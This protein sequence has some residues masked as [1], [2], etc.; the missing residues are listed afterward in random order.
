MNEKMSSREFVS[1]FTDI[2][3]SDRSYK[4]YTDVP[5]TDE[6]YRRLCKS[7]QISDFLNPNKTKGRL[8]PKLSEVIYERC[9]YCLFP[10][11]YLDY[12][13]EI[14]V[15]KEVP[16]PQV[17]ANKF[18][19]LFSCI[20]DYNL[21]LLKLNDND[22]EELTVNKKEYICSLIKVMLNHF[23]SK[24]ECDIS[25][26]KD[27]FADAFKIIRKD[28]SIQPYKFTAIEL[29]EFERINSFC[30]NEQNTIPYALANEPET[31]KAHYENARNTFVTILNQY[32]DLYDSESKTVLISK[33]YIDIRGELFGIYNY[34]NYFK[35]FLECRDLAEEYL[36]RF[37]KILSS[38]N[39]SDEENYNKLNMADNICKVLQEICNYFTFRFMVYSE[40]CADEIFE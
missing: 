30:F 5:E 40:F 34:G 20:F 27:D 22:S 1:Y 23:K 29:Y 6:R 13:N 33:S 36:E 4:V 15:Q 7:G 35:N 38:L 8:T 24:T 39:D 3:F 32:I 37:E 21:G 18:T 25:K 11:E 9:R 12:N 31:M 2:L 19:C 26:L 14:P 16:T 10:E 28:I 17:F